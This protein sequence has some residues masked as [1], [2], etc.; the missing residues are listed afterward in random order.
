M[1]FTHL[2]FLFWM[3]LRCRC[4]GRISL[5]HSE[6]V[7]GSIPKSF[8]L[9]QPLPL[10]I[11]SKACEEYTP[12]QK[13]KLDRRTQPGS[14]NHLAKEISGWGEVWLRLIVRRPT[15]RHCGK[16]FC[17]TH[18]GFAKPEQ[19]EATQSWCGFVNKSIIFCQEVITNP[20]FL[21]SVQSKVG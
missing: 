12:L 17:V 2:Y 13:R 1:C 8:S 7:W 15:Q 9:R 20:G 5:W 14:F 21:W 11:Y 4:F 19:R 16:D 3:A 6:Q 10:V 18:T